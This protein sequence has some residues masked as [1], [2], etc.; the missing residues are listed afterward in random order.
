[1]SRVTRYRRD[2]ARRGLFFRPLFFAPCHV[3]TPARFHAAVFSACLRRL[4]CLRSIM[5][6]WK[7]EVALRREED[8]HTREELFTHC[9]HTQPR[10]YSQPSAT[11]PSTT[12]G[13]RHM[14]FPPAAGRRIYKRRRW[15]EV[16][17]TTVPVSLPTFLR[18]HYHWVTEG[19]M[20]SRERLARDEAC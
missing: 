7:I 9:I 13:M 11:T 4:P 12:E 3:I 18:A 5:L 19:E 8:E 14:K 2:A 10:T 16:V 20:R 1:M 6:Q 17:I 15:R